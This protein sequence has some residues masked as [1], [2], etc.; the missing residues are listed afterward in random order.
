MI[1]KITSDR[2][3]SPLEKLEPGSKGAVKGKM[4][5]H[6]KGEMNHGET[7]G[8]EKDSAFKGSKNSK[9]KKPL[10]QVTAPHKSKNRTPRYS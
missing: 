2:K 1:K 6:K 8:K 5:T 3:S 9:G 10:S 7:M 4:M